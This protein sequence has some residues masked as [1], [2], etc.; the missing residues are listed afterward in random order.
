M[1][2]FPLE[3]LDMTRYMTKD[4]DLDWRSRGK[5]GYSYKSSWFPWSSKPR[6]APDFQ[7]NQTT[8]YSL[9]GVVNHHGR[10]NSGH[11]TGMSRQ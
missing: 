2:D 11:Y 6:K 8:S 1:V 4:S 3:H 5:N 10:L 9:F 7:L